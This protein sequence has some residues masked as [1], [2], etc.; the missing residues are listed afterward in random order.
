[1]GASVS[2]SWLVYWQVFWDDWSKYGPNIYSIIYHTRSKWF[3]KAVKPGDDVWLVVSGGRSNPGL[4]YL[5]T[6]FTVRRKSFGRSKWRQYRLL[7][8]LRE[9]DLFCLDRQADMSPILRRLAFAS[10]RRISVRGGLI[11]MFLQTP[12]RLATQDLSTLRGHMS[13]L[14][15]I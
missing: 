8:E 13:R 2:T 7:P 4:W 15:R 10:G 1:M 3:Y 12:R 9:W 6:R 5:A 11:G 14:R